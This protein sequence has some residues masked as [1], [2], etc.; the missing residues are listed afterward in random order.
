MSFVVKGN[1]AHCKRFVGTR[2]GCKCKRCPVCKYLD[3][4][5]EKASEC[6]T[7]IFKLV[8]PCRVCQ[9][10][11]CVNPPE[12]HCSLEYICPRCS[13][14]V[15]PSDRNATSKYLKIH[16]LTHGCK[17]VRSKDSALPNYKT[18]KVPNHQNPE[19]SSSCRKKDENKLK[20]D[21][22]AKQDSIE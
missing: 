10:D 2:R 8:N 3:A 4:D 5:C 21:E 7:C 19:T 17:P 13:V 9:K 15:K 16:A 14:I 20:K 6:P 22:K 1:C 12:C 18:S 11:P